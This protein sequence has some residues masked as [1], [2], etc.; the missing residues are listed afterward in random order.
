MLRALIADDEMLA[1]A[2]IRE[3][4]DTHPDVQ[5]VAEAADGLEAVQALQAHEPDLVFLDI[6]MPR[7]T[8]LELLQQTGWR[9]GVIFT[10]AYDQ[11]AMAAFD[12]HAVDY[13]LKPFSQAR[14]DAA[15]DRARRLRRESEAAIDKLLARQHIERV[16]IRDGNGQRVL[17]LGEVDYIEAQ[18][19]YVAYCCA[20][21]EHLKAQRISE[22]ET[23]LDPQRFVR[24]HRSYIVNVA[25]VQAVERTASEGHAL[26]LH[27]GKRIPVS[28]SGYERLR[29]VL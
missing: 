24:V 13:L 15:L 16:L 21:R 26:R 22:L 14:F 11:H 9:R 12:L 5:I 3:Y 19:D 1:R 23:Q 10:T 27:S 25:R 4:L 2:L 28:R 6:Q 7:L 18:A 20:G 17:A 29:E 8:G